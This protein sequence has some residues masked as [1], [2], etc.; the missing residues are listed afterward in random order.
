MAGRQVLAYCGKS[1]ELDLSSEAGVFSVTL[2]DRRSGVAMPQPIPVQGG[3]KV[4]L[5]AA[6]G[7]PIVVWLRKQY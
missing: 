7:L 2:I 1:T 6:N 3:G 4:S 5:P